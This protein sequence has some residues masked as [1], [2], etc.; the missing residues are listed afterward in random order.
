MGVQG[1]SELTVLVDRL[2]RDRRRDPYSGRDAYSRTAREVADRCEELIEAGEA[3]AAVPVLRKAVDRMTGAL[4]YM[5]SSSGVLGN[6]LAYLMEVYARA[7]RAAPPRPAGL[8]AWLVKLVCDGPGWPDVVLREWAPAL[9]PKGLAKVARLVDERAVAGTEPDGW[10]GQWAVRYL[11]EQI[12]EISGDVDRY[13]QVLAEHLVSAAQYGR[14]VTVLAQAQRPAEAIDW[15]RR[16]LAAH[17]S[18]HQAV[19]LR[20][21]LVRLLIETGEPEAAVAERRTA[22]DVQPTIDNFRSLLATVADTDRDTAHTEAALTVVRERATGQAGY[23][24]HLI[25]VLTL[26]GHDDEAWHTGLARWD[27]VPARQRVELVEL[28]RRTH[29][30]EVREPYQALIDAQ[31]LD[32]YDKRRYDKTITLLSRLREAYVATGEVTRFEAYLE[33]LRAEHRRRPTFLAKL[34]AA[35]LQSGR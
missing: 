31:L 29:P 17:P 23:L 2:R 21:L 27:E 34:D 24:P 9:G 35:R 25:D 26:A 5:D 1:D 20:D 33:A 15:A 14:I 4:M 32:S 8:A 10:H 22:F 28:R 18:G 19:A 12:A 7:C 30:A 11:R 13:V 6:D 16:G 3:S